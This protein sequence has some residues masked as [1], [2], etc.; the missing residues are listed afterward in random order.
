MHIIIKKGPTNSAFHPHFNRATGVY[1][2]TKA[3]YLS[4]LKAKHLEPY[5]PNTPELTQKPYELSK[6]GKA[7][8]ASIKSHTK[9]GKVYLSDTMKDEF[10]KRGVKFPKKVKLNKKIST[11]KGGFI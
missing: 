2:H 7:M 3:D 5:N 11:K 10:K 9:D 1:Y 4:D 8:M 6:W